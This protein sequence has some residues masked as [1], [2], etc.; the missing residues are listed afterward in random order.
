MNDPLLIVDGFGLAFSEKTILADVSFQLPQRGIT[1]LVGPGAAGKS[2]LV[3]SLAGLNG[4]RPDVRFWGEVTYNGLPLGLAGYPALVLQQT[5]LLLSS[6]FENLV[7]EL[8]K[9]SELTR[10]RQRQIATAM[11]E[12]AGLEELVPR[13]DQSV[14]DLPLGL[15]RRLAIARTAATR[16][17]LLCVDEPTAD[18]DDVAASAI[19]NQLSAVAERMAVLVVTHR[20]DH[21]I[22]LGG[23]T[24]LLAGGKILEHRPTAEFF[25]QPQSEAA[26]Q[27]VR[28]G[29]CRQ[30]SAA[31][32]PEELEPEGVDLIQHNK[33]S[34]RGVQPVPAGAGPRGFVWLRPG[35]LGGM[36]Y[37]GLLRRTEL[38]LDSLEAIGVT[39]LFCLTQELPPTDPALLAKYGIRGHVLPMAD[40]SAPTI[41]AA[42]RM[43]ELVASLLASGRSVAMHCKA[44]L[45]RTGT[46]LAAQ[47][48]HEGASAPHALETV[49]RVEPRWVQSE[50]QL[51]FLREFAAAVG[52]KTRVSISIPTIK[53]DGAVILGEPT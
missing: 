21:A 29:G 51:S 47:L 38:D 28:T 48:I 10:A 17:P 19:L 15:Q 5:R 11:L 36:P 7:S 1:A 14:V 33:P 2:T 42:L 22:R 23:S 8:P 45:G 46:M 16:P 50:T 20:Q 41:P 44:G 31:A 37:P 32:R 27:F 52:G 53:P 26:R 18:V 30:P 49:R 24:L 43:C 9:R 3:R 35:R 40:M 6:V 13:L 25:T 4:L 39:D 34:A 12:R